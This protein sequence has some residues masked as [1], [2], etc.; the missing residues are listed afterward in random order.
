MLVDGALEAAGIDRRSIVDER[1]G[2]V[3]LDT[4]ASSPDGALAGARVEIDPTTGAVAAVRVRVDAGD[5][6]DATVLRSYAIGATHMAL[7]WV[8]TEGL[9]VDPESGEVLDLTIRSFGIIR[10]RSM[11]PVTVEIVSRDDPP[12]AARRRRRVR[13]RRGGCVE[14]DHPRGRH[15]TRVVPGGRDPR[16]P[17][18]APVTVEPIP[19]PGAPPV[20]GPYSPAVRAGDWLVLAGQVPLDPATGQLVTGDARTQ[21]KRV[22]DNLRLVLAD[23]GATLADVAKTTVFVTDLSDFGAMNEVYAEAFGDHRPARSTVQ[24]AALPGGAAVEI[25]AWAHVPVR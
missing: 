10:P 12:R 11:P 18:A 2:A 4:V 16:R 3:L 25:E 9:A 8:L 6:L 17:Y 14:R 20:A 24:V 7:G 23:C 1:A 5:P 21:A 13:G 15:P 19:T 22:L